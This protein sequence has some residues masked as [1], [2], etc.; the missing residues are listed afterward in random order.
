MSTAVKISSELRTWID[1]NLNR[2]CAPEQLIEGMI[3]ERFEPAIARG[4]VEAF[5]QARA[6]GT[7]VAGDTLTLN[8]AA[9]A[10]GGDWR[11]ATIFGRSIG[12]SR[13]CCAWPGPR[14]P[15]SAVC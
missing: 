4:L 5:V 6:A 7:P 8:L 9:P 15:F 14:S 13:C 10:Y 12:P 2:G 3:V 11:R 1:H